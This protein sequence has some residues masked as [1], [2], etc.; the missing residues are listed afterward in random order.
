M[1][2]SMEE[3]MDLRAFRALRDVGA[4]WAEIARETG[5]DWRTV[6]K[7]LSP[8]ACD[9]PAAVTARPAGEDQDDRAL[10][11]AHRHLTEERTLP[12]GHR[13]PPAPGG[14]P[15]LLRFLPADQALRGRGPGALVSHAVRV[16]PALRGPCPAP[17]PRWTGA[18]RVSLRCPTGPSTSGA[19]T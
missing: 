13:D 19:S 5:R 3:W 1:L 17:R 14:R 15:R 7:Y 8:G 4:T 9:R 2:V 6:K 10:C 18:T 12:A 16:A 11:G